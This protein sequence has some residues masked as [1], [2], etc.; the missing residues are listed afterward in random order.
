MGSFWPMRG[1]GRII[2]RTAMIGVLASSSSWAQQSPGLSTKPSGRTLSEPS[3][4]PAELPV[5]LSRPNP[6]PL[7][8][9][10]TEEEKQFSE[11][12]AGGNT[13]AQARLGIIYVNSRSD[14]IRLKLGLELLNTAASQGSPDALFELAKM[15]LAG[16]GVERSPTA[17]FDF[18]RRAAELGLPDAEYE[19]ASMYSEGR[20][21]AKDPVAALNWARKAAA[22]SHP[23]ATVS[24]GSMMLQSPD[25]T[26]RS[27]GLRKLTQAADGGNKDAALSLATA[28]AKGEG[29]LPKDEIAAEVL[30]K[31]HAEE[32]NADFQ[33]ALASLYN[34]GEIFAA[35]RV[36]A[37]VWLKRAA[38]QG[39]PKA[40]E[41]LRP[42]TKQQPAAGAGSDL[43]SPK[44]PARP[45][46]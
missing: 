26:S 42:E 37:H 32:G 28:Y 34:F 38:D 11:A 16:R 13:W 44:K 46:E 45:T 23:K 39:H 14:L 2:L 19:L 3:A 41:I 6:Q 33:F 15:A 25:P 31:K 18:M 8:I 7:K 9:E 29:G 4:P 21:T 22:N 5:D 1:F 43:L 12:A 40:L 24:I 36:E 30:L 17:A 20:G 10:L 35:R 27:E